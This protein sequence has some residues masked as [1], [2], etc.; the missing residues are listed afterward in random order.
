MLNRP[1]IESLTAADSA[2]IIDLI[3]SIQPSIP[4]TP[5]YLYWQYFE[6][7]AG[8]ARLYGIR[9]SGKL[10]SLYAAVAHRLRLMNCILT[11]R[12][13]QDVMTLPEYRGRGYLHELAKRCLQ[14]IIVAGELG[15]TFPNQKSEKSFRRTGWTE[16]CFVPWRKKEVSSRPVQHH[17]QSTAITSITTFGVAEYEI[18]KSSAARI[19]IQK[20]PAYLNWRY[21]KPGNTYFRF[22]TN[23]NEGFLVLKVYN[24]GT[25]KILHICELLL[26]ADKCG[27][28][29]DVL[30]FCERFAFEHGA[31]LMTAWLTEFDSYSQGFTAA[32]F[33]L[34]KDSGRYIFVHPGQQPL[35]PFTDVGLW[36][37]SQGDSDIY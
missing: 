2:Q 22:A 4:W 3:N 12:M 30:H 35:V 23:H 24:D 33:S 28:L 15:F 14:D 1:I 6:S 34:V 17:G 26:R 32:G 21:S 36:Q 9:D 5:E 11:A 8:I 29:S 25:R 20:D 10:V 16:L 18:W 27:R 19:G 31:S 7:P 37:L 13:V